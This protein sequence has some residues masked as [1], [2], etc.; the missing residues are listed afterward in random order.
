[1]THL[2]SSRGSLFE[3]LSQDLQ[4]HVVLCVS[5]LPYN[6]T[7]G[8]LPKEIVKLFF[9]FLK[10]KVTRVQITTDETFVLIPNNHYSQ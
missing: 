6:A 3:C 9:F 8:V 1:M 2:I 7:W 10:K 5:K 4:W